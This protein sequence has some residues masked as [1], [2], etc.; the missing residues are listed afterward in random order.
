L[1]FFP[2]FKISRC[3]ALAPSVRSV[4]AVRPAECFWN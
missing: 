4:M 3:P 1:F 2:P